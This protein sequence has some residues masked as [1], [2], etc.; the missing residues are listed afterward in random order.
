[1]VKLNIVGSQKWNEHLIQ[2]IESSSW[3]SNVQPILSCGHKH[4]LPHHFPLAHKINTY[5]NAQPNAY[6]NGFKDVVLFL[7][8]IITFKTMQRWFLIKWWKKVW[9]KLKTM[10]TMRRWANCGN[11]RFIVYRLSH[12]NATSNFTWHC[13]LHHAF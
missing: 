2:L 12:L 5:Y 6:V 10:S 1:M 7:S 11:P 8:F 3:T 13:I 4:L 9:P